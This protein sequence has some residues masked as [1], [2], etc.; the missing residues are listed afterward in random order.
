MAVASDGKTRPPV[1][2]RSGKNLETY[3]LSVLNPGTRGR[4]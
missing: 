2:T 1:F 3:N 4:G